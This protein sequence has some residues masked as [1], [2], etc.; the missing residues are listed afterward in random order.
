MGHSESSHR[1]A[2]PVTPAPSKPLKTEVTL[3]SSQVSGDQN[4]TPP[5]QQVLDADSYLDP[6]VLDSSLLTLSGLTEVNV[7][8][9]A[10]G[11]VSWLGMVGL[12]LLLLQTTLRHFPL[13]AGPCWA[14]E[15]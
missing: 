9:G 15:E 3:L 14:S 6:S 4:P 5:G 8:P 2:R 1:K 10:Q 12:S 7:S 11:R 13:S